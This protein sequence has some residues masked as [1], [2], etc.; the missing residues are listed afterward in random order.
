MCSLIN[1]GRSKLNFLAKWFVVV[2]KQ[3]ILYAHNR[4]IVPIIDF[5]TFNILHVTSLEMSLSQYALATVDTETIQI[6][7]LEYRKGDWHN[8]W[9][10]MNILYP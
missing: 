5:S 4:Y 8:F 6:N 9:Q 2:I 10:A 3:W 1:I 7:Y